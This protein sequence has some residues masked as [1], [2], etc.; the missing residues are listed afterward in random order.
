MHILKQNR[1]IV[2]FCLI[3]VLAMGEMSMAESN[4]RI[5]EPNVSGQFYTSDASQLSQEIDDFIS[6][7]QVQPYKQHVDIVIA[8]HAG[9]MYSGGVA[10]YG[11]KAASQNEYST[12][13]VLAPSHYYGFDGISI[14]KEG[15]FRTPLGSIAVDDSMAKALIASGENFFFAPQAFTQEHS[16]EVEIPFI[17]KT[18]P[19][20]KIVPVILGQPN[21]QTLKDFGASLNKLIGKRKDVLVVVSTDLSHFHDDAK[22]RSLDE[23]AMTAIAKLDPESLWKR[24]QLRKDMEMC[25]FVPVTAALLY[26]QQKGLNKVD[27]L[28]YANSG[29]VS[30]DRDRVVGY[31]SIVIYGE[32]GESGVKEDGHNQSVSSLTKEQRRR[33][34]AIA[35]DTVELYVREKKVLEVN[36]DDPRLNEEEGAFV[37]LRKKNGEL[38]GCIGNVL[39]SGPLHLTVR[40]M[41]ISAA[42]KDP[43]F[44]PVESK[45]LS[46]IDVEVSVLSK[47]RRIKNVDEIQMGTHGVIVKKGPFHQGLYLPQVADETGWSKEQFLSS[48]CAHKA[49]LPQ[50]AWKD[51]KTH[52]EIFT[53]DVFSEHDVQ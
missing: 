48:L 12:I 42:T 23:N 44:S 20:A 39:G 4:N 19:K 27:R 34:I 35:R 9:H 36:E 45:E 2:F 33:L 30:G 40:N 13:I 32:E 8:P 28:H 29:D 41:A 43:R 3:V 16:L 1:I 46:D 15:E 11:F 37:T 53:A 6:K 10:A 38:R 24:A 50:D 17:Q 22:A 18:F 52:I 25:G 47:P 14:W 31:T 51:P 21:F 49:G 26:A 5:K 7:A